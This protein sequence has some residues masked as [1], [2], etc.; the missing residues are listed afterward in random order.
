MLSRLKY[1]EI[2][3]LDKELTI[4]RPGKLRS[5]LQLLFEQGYLPLETLLDL[6]EVEIG[7]LTKLTGI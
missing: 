5:I 3:P 4:P 2:E 1:N 7:F 6:L